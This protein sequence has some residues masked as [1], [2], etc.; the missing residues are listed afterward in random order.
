MNLARQTYGKDEGRD[1]GFFHGIIKSWSS[2]TGMIHPGLPIPCLL[3]GLGQRGHN[4]SVLTGIF[5][6]SPV[7]QHEDWEGAGD[8]AECPG[9]HVPPG[10]ASGT[11]IGVQPPFPHLPV[12]TGT[13]LAREKDLA[14]SFC[15][16]VST[17][18]H[19]CSHPTAEKSGKLLIAMD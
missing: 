19:P 18:H 10:I 4:P 11:S 9:P 7:S 6:V 16:P 8:F 13:Q 12:P 17:Y 2:L 14:P 3:A 1:R 15:S 5:L